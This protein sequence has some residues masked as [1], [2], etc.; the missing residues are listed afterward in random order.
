MAE[1]AGCFDFRGFTENVAQSTA[2]RSGEIVEAETLSEMLGV[3]HE[4]KA[5]D[6][7]FVEL[8]AKAAELEKLVK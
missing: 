8:D 4:A 1:D 2:V 5:P 7:P 6:A 3:W